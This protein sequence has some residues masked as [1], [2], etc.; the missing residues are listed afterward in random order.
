MVD[1]ELSAAL[2]PFAVL[3]EHRLRR[4]FC[5]GLTEEDLSSYKERIGVLRSM[6]KEQIPQLRKQLEEV[7]ALKKGMEENGREKTEGYSAGLAALAVALL[8][9]ALLVLATRS[10]RAPAATASPEK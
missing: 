3:L 10:P 5:E 7:R 9:A 4:I 2:L 6:E 1:H 8:V